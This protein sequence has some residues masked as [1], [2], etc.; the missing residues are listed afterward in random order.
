MIFLFCAFR[1]EIS[2]RTILWITEDF[3]NLRRNVVLITRDCFVKNISHDNWFPNSNNA[4]LGT[5]NIFFSIFLRLPTVSIHPPKQTPMISKVGLSIWNLSRLWRKRWTTE[6]V[7]P[8]P[9]ITL[10]AVSRFRWPQ[11]VWAFPS[12]Y[13]TERL[14][15]YDHRENC[16]EFSIF[17]IL[18]FWFLFYTL[19]FHV[20]VKKFNGKTMR[21]KSSSPWRWSR[22]CTIVAHPPRGG[23][24]KKKLTRFISSLNFYFIFLLVDR[25]IAFCGYTSAAEQVSTDIPVLYQEQER[26]LLE[27]Y[28]SNVG[29]NSLKNRTR[30]RQ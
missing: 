9:V 2:S 15:L 20:I 17:R 23:K 29:V 1:K 16:G 18:F 14:R 10:P 24:I 13:F 26:P 21:K 12:T 27:I 4:L 5:P 22:G 3:Y 25:H 19:L 28:C 11:P 6:K 8:G 7:F 30:P